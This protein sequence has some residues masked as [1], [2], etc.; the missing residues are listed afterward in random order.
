MTRRGYRKCTKCER[1]RA[2][3]FYKG[4]GRVCLDCQRTRSRTA[5][6]DRRILDTYGLTAEEYDTLFEA[7]GEACAVC[8][9]KR[10]QKLSVDHCH[11]TGAVRGLLCRLCNGRL[12]TAAKD[13]PDVLR[14]AADY[15]ENYPC[16]RVLGRRVIPD[17][18]ENG[19]PPIGSGAG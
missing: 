17:V 2:V 18:S 12:L 15:L 14:R 11:K 7:Q 4:R 3:R 13:N 10:R 1:N 19:R 9:G 5:A 16:D 8:L 6:R